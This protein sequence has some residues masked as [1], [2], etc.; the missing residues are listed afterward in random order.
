MCLHVMDMETLILLAY[1]S[2]IVCF[3]MY[4][5]QGITEKKL[6]ETDLRKFE[7]SSQRTCWCGYVLLKH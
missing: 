7:Q 6:I 3:Y 2:V 4:F 5:G 1:A